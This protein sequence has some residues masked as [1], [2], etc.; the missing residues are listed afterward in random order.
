MITDAKDFNISKMV[1]LKE[2][3]V[4]L[5]QHNTIFKRIPIKVMLNQKLVPLLIATEKCFLWGIKKDNPKIANRFNK[6]GTHNRWAKNVFRN[7]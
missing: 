6:Q 7:D 4:T 3:T 2:K 1:F 5:S